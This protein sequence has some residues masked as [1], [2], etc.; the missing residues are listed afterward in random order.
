MNRMTS[1]AYLDLAPGAIEGSVVKILE[2]LDIKQLT[3][4]V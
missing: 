4:S 2:G 1:L 3:A